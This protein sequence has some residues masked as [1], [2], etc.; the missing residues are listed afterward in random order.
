MQRKKNQRHKVH[1]F[2]WSGST[3]KKI[4]HWFEH[5]VDALFFA[6]CSGSTAVKIYHDDDLVHSGKPCAPDGY[7]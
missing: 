2:K 6:N 5:F 7:A 4:E 3:L 1:L